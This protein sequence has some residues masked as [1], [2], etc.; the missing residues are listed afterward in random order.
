MSKAGACKGCG[1][2]LITDVERQRGYCTRCWAKLLNSTDDEA[3][4]G[5]EG[6]KPESIEGDIEP[7]EDEG[8][9]SIEFKGPNKNRVCS[10]IP[11][12]MLKAMIIR[13][14][15]METSPSE[16]IR[17]LVEADLLNHSEVLE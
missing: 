10:R 14:Q 6:I 3:R 16:Y 8:R 7:V 11:D 5:D 17:S 9:V 2:K 15:S 4:K 1:A 12:S 13:M